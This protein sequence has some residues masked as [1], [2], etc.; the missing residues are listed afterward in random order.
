M[1]PPSQ[2]FPC[3]LFAVLL[4]VALA[5]RA[6]A[7]KPAL[8]LEAV[9]V[10]PAAPRPDALCHLTVTVKSSGAQVASSLEFV[11]K[12]NGQELAAYK[13]RLYLTPVEPGATREVRLFNFWSTETGR[14]AP[15][16]GKLS[17]EVTLARASWVRKASRDG[18]EVWTPAGEVQGLPASR[19]VTL[20]MAK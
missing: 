2:R 9:K 3:L 17:V 20:T 7:P 6:E 8:T 16:N 5:A 12:V 13:K 4:G 15:A 1:R 14:P 18:A 19:N 11:V 10:E